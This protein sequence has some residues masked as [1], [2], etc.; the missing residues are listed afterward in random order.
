MKV[1]EVL[2]RVVERQVHGERL[3]VYELGEMIF[4]Q[5]GLDRADVGRCGPEQLGDD[6]P[7]GR[8]RNGWIEEHA[9]Q[10]LVPVD[11]IGELDQVGLDLP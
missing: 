6:S 5:L 11:E 10:G 2:G 9:A 1:V 8:R 7:F 4:H 3:L